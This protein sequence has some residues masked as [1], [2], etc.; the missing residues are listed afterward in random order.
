MLC[1]VCVRA[2]GCG[3]RCGGCGDV[4]CIVLCVLRDVCGML[5]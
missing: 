4:W 1:V 3:V 5:F 2:C